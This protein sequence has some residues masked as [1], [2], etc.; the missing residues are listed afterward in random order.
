MLQRW[1]QQVMHPERYHG[2]NKKKRFFEG[3]Y[4]KL[5]DAKGKRSLAIIPGVFMGPESKDHHSFIHLLD[6]QSGEVDFIT[7]PLEAFQPQ[8]GDFSVQLADN[9]FHGKGLRLQLPEQGVSGELHFSEMS[10]WPV[11]YGSPGIMG[12]YG[13][14]PFMECFHGVLSLDHHIEGS[15][16]F[17]GETIDFSGGRGY[18]EKDWGKAFPSTW[19]WLQS[20]HFPVE[21]TCLTASVARIPWFGGAFRGFIMGFWHEQILYRFATYTGAKLEKLTADEQKV[22]W[23]VRDK[24]YRL[25]IE[26]QR[27]STYGLLYAPTYQAMEPKVHEYLNAVVDVQFSELTKGGENIL[28]EGRG[29]HTGMEA[30]GDIHLFDD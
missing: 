26:A 13:W 12:W 7:F 18:I 16:D 10:P 21:G 11:T 19:I 15:I 2:A 27:G 5:V 28:F 20:N 6:G 3:W 9:H 1:I 23:I 24:K 30:E 8:Q 4:Y 29:E 17:K 22:L 14:M 25:K